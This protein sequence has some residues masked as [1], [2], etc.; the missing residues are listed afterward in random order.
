MT[1]NLYSRVR[2]AQA[3]EYWERIRVLTEEEPETALMLRVL[4]RAAQHAANEVEAEETREWR[5]GWPPLAGPQ[6]PRGIQLAKRR[7]DEA[8]T[9]IDLVKARLAVRHADAA[10]I[11]DANAAMNDALQRLA[12]LTGEAAS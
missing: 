2:E 5:E 1:D 3:S 12:A 7:L 8:E 11:G 9:A 6:Q 10:S 4:D